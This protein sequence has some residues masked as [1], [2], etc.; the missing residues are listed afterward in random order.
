MFKPGIQMKTS[1]KHYIYLFLVCIYCSFTNAFADSIP[2]ESINSLSEDL[3]G[4][5]I[6]WR[7][8]FHQ[9]PKRSNREFRTAGI[10]TV[11]S[12]HG[13]VRSNI[14]PRRGRNAGDHQGA[15]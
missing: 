11:G 14:I 1:R 10:V 9:N 15:G 2:L 6:A 12:I 13:Q 5:V 4:D 7:R 8:D 3:S